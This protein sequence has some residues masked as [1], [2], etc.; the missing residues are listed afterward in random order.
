MAIRFRKNPYKATLE[1]SAKLIAPEEDTCEKILGAVMLSAGV[2]TAATFAT[3]ATNA[4]ALSKAAS[5]GKIALLK[6]ATGVA[7]ATVGAV[8][9][10]S[11]LLAPPEIQNVAVHPGESYTQ[12]AIIITTDSALS[13]QSVTVISQEG[14][15]RS[16]IPA[17]RGQ[18][19]VSVDRNGAYTV[20]VVSKTGQVVTADVEVNTID[21]TIPVMERYTVDGDSVAIYFTDHQSGVNWDSIS[22]TDSNG[23]TVPPLAV[24]PD[25]GCAVFALPQ[26]NLDVTVE[27]LAGNRAVATIT[28]E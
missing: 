17:Q 15:P 1:E 20:E 16:A 2:A 19:T 24:Y 26:S 12:S 22:A 10:S 13:P 3:A 14:V 28:V 5:L 27:D 25:Q 9:T 6:V 21:E 23:Q 7:V 18:Y 4:A 8:A 11:V